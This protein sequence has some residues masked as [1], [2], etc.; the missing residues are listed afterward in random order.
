MFGILSI[1]NMIQIP[2]LR[3]SIIISLLYSVI[4]CLPYFFIFG[5]PPNGEPARETTRLIIWG[6]SSFI[7]FIIPVA[8]TL[9]I[10]KFDNSL[11]LSI[12]HCVERLGLLVV[13]V[14][15]E[16]IIGFL[17]DHTNSLV[18]VEIGLIVASFIVS[19]F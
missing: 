10:I 8:R 1:G 17:F 19:E 9:F 6:L 4:S 5:L 3:A 11:A 7:S 15:G 12:E 16:I 14:L 18:T 13:I 2:K